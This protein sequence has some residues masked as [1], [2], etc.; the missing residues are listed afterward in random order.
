MDAVAVGISDAGLTVKFS[1][2][3]FPFGAQ[4]RTIIQEPL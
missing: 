2:A 3:P 1:V 4:I